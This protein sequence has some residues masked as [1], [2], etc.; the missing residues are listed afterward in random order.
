M[1]K[2]PVMNNGLRN[3]KWQWPYLKLPKGTLHDAVLMNIPQIEK[4]HHDLPP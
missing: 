4:S 3:K 2:H 1:S